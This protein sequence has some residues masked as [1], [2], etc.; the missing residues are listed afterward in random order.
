MHAV[1]Q[2]LHVPRY[3]CPGE[4][5]PWN[6]R[7]NVI[8][9]WN[10]FWVVSPVSSLWN[11]AAWFFQRP[12]KNDSLSIHQESSLV[13]FHWNN[14][15]TRVNVE[16][17]KNKRGKKQKVFFVPKYACALIRRLH[18]WPNWLSQ[19]KMIQNKC[20]TKWHS[21]PNIM[22][23]ISP[24]PLPKNILTWKYEV[25]P[26]TCDQT[27]ILYPTIKWWGLHIK[28]IWAHSVTWLQ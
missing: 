16:L 17:L 2:G 18:A 28:R 6:W 24:T 27:L 23:G 12:W 10:P 20:K 4:T 5:S 8:G 3:D 1:G 15:K 9:R 26:M 22:T 25:C 21:A 7:Q 11:K 13:G 19:R 14:W